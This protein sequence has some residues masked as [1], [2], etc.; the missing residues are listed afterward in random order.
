MFI[1]TDC[2]DFFFPLTGNKLCGKVTP[3]VTAN[4]PKLACLNLTNTCMQSWEELESL[5]NFPSLV[6]VRL[7]GVP[8]CENIVEAERRQLCIARLGNVSRLNGSPVGYTEKEDAERAFIRYYMDSTTKPT[9][10][11]GFL[12][13]H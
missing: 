8:F 1:V 4:F 12:S 11:V 5:N 2:F 6:D 13:D 7:Q 3:E 9:R 10:L